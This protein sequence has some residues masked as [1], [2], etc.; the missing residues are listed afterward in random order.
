M[1]PLL[2]PLIISSLTFTSIIAQAKSISTQRMPQ[3][4]SISASIP[5]NETAIQLKKVDTKVEIIGN[6]AE[7]TLELTLFNPNKRQLEG[8]LEFP[9]QE[10]QN[11]T[12]LALDINGE[13]RDAV[14]VPKAKGRQVFEA[15]ER[16]RVDPALLE[17][18]QGNN[19]K[20]RVYPIPARGTR[21][22][23][24]T[25]QEILSSGAEGRKYSLPTNFGNHVNSYQL[26]VLVKGFEQAP[27]SGQLKFSA[28]N[29]QEFKASLQKNNIE[30]LQ[31]IDISIPSENKARLY[32]QHFKNNDYFFAEIPLSKINQER[33]LPSKI[34]ILWDASL[35]G[36]NR[37]IQSELVLLDAYFKKVANADIEVTILRQKIGKP[38]QFKI[39]N[40]DWS[41]LKKYLENI[42]YDGATNLSTWINNTNIQEYLLF[43][44][45]LENF[46]KTANIAL[47]PNQRLYSIHSDIDVNNALRLRQ[48]AE[49]HQGQYIT[50]NDPESFKQAQQMLLQDSARII[51]VEGKGIHDIQI[52]SYLAENG[53]VGI[54]GQYS[55]LVGDQAALEIKTRQ[56]NE[57]RSV[58]LP[59]KNAI[60]SKQI[61]PLWAKHKVIDLNQNA[62]EHEKK[63]LELGQK[64]NI[65]TPNTS[66][67]VL[68]NLSDYLQYEIEPP[69]SLLAEYQKAVQNR[70]N[71][72]QNQQ[73]QSLENA[74]KNYKDHQEWW[75]KKWP[76]DKP[77]LEA[78]EKREGQR[79]RPNPFS[80]LGGG[81]FNSNA[82]IVADAPPAPA[83]VHTAQRTKRPQPMMTRH[84]ASS[85]SSTNRTSSSNYS[86][87]IQAWK[88]NA[89]YVSRLENASNQQAYNIYLDERAENLNN[90][91]FYLTVSDIFIRKGMQ[92]EAIQVVSNL[93]ELN[94]ENRYILRLL[95]QQLLILK[96]YQDAIEAY[97][98]VLAMAEEEPQSWRDLA[99]AYAENKQYNDAIT[100]MYEV[101]KR[102]WD[103]RFGGIQL[104]ATDELNNFIAKAPN[105][106]AIKNIDSKLIKNLP[107]GMRV[108][109]TW[110]SDNSDMDLWIIDP[111]QEK[112]YYGHKQSY[113]GGKISNDFTGGYG[114]EVFWLK[115]PKKGEYTVKAHFYGDRQ[116]IVTGPTTAFVR[117]I[118]NWGKPNQSEEILRVKM[119]KERLNTQTDGAVMI[120]KFIVK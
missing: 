70:W 26:E 103:S 67:I 27:S 25:Y 52:P 75:N 83:T 98:K 117:L 86:I 96:Q 22:V 72:K 108:V 45:G 21:I 18:T 105:S 28:Q 32:T 10:G 36:K 5:A 118:R 69:A 63:I 91:S 61:A 35:S 37:D 78:N 107:V 58:V 92:Q 113:Q 62:V 2:L 99:L 8:T 89:P 16:R 31:H 51:Q 82:V 13:M 73:E 104:I 24:I 30:Q 7:T 60:E 12:A 106:P 93:A 46:G 6:L 29:N 112:T 71:V 39:K 109:L 97:K 81:S 44:D 87:E 4:I 74:I 57:V 64:F 90:P 9:L 23:K 65:V 19:F 33:Q 54:Y 100:T 11:I 88:E 80:S 66:L 47:K 50:W 76:K 40:G 14:P 94:L 15:I 120:G 116:Q 56:G 119:T 1:K 48:I 77:Q 68:E 20:L 111:N 95:G 55:R 3:R 114:P 17:Q 101:V 85:K 102:S 43:S 59:F 38:T 41:E 53:L 84:A 42:Q 115:E 110:D 34:G 79:G 49:K